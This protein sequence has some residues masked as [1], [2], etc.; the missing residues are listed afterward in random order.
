[1]A[2]TFSFSLNVTPLPDNDIWFANAAAWSNYWAQQTGGTVT[3]NPIATTIYTPQPFDNTLLVEDI[4]IDGVDH[5]LPSLAMF[6]SLVNA[7]VACDNAL[8]DLRSQLKAAGLIT[9]A[10]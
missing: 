2:I 10:Q 7:F 8:K 9:N 5:N 6:Q 4:R 3:L 1:M